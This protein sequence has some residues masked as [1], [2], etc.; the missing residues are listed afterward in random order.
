VEKNEKEEAEGKA[1]VSTDG[2]W[3]FVFFDELDHAC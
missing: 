1:K 3:L 2:A